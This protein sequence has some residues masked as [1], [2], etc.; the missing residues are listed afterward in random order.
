MIIKWALCG[1]PYKHGMSAICAQML[2]PDDFVH[3][4]YH[5]KTYYKVY[6]PAIMPM[7]SSRLWRKTG[8]IPPLPPNFGKKRG[9]PKKTRKP[10][11]DEDPKEKKKRN[12]EK[13]GSIKLNKQRWKVH[14]HFCG[15]EGHNKKGCEWR[16][17]AERF[18]LD[19]ETRQTQPQEEMT[20]AN[21]IPMQEQDTQPDQGV[22]TTHSQMKLT[23]SD[24]FI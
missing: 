11:A 17:F 14:C 1:I 15:E 7:N 21:D 16:K 5:V 10:S 3:S 13:K 20:Q 8:Y 12:K 22:Q 4:S 24:C 19:E 23:V 2:D 6:E 9:R 18:P